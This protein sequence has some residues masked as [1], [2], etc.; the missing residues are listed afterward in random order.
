MDFQ[1]GGE[2]WGAGQ[3]KGG[4]KPMLPCAYGN[5][6]EENGSKKGELPFAVTDR[7][8]V[9]GPLLYP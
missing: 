1:E 8:N 9:L 2:R 7:V 4:G 3:T 6:R 5:C